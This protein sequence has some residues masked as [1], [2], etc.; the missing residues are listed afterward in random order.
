MKLGNIIIALIVTIYIITISVLLISGTAPVIPGKVVNGASVLFYIISLSVLGISILEV[1]IRM[2]QKHSY[3]DDRDLIIRA[4]T[5]SDGAGYI[6]I[7][8]SIRML[9][10][11]VVITGSVIACV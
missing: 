6:L 7:A 3:G 5:G 11:S 4:M 2:Y 8:N 9:S 1:A 10:Y